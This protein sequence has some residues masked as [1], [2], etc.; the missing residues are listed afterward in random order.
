MGSGNG[1]N[2]LIS[3]M[4]RFVMDL[5]KK[6]PTDKFERQNMPQLLCTC[7]FYNVSLDK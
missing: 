7:Q 3:T 2:K 1:K 6:V 4:I 5:C